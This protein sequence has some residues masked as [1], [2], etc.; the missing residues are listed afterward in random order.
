MVFIIL[1]LLLWLAVSADQCVYPQDSCDNASY[2]Q[3]YPLCTLLQQGGGHAFAC[4]GEPSL[5]GLSKPASWHLHMLFPNKNCENCSAHFQRERPGF[6]FAGA[7]LF[8]ERVANFLNQLVVK[9]KGSPPRLAINGTRARL[10]LNYNVCGEIFDIKAGAPANFVDEPCIY[11]V[12]S[13]M[14]HGGPWRNPSLHEGYPN[15]SFFLPG[16][17]WLP[18]AVPMLRAWLDSERSA[19]GGYGQYTFAI[20]PNTGCES[21]DHFK[22]IE[23]LGP[24]LPLSDDFSCNALGCNQMCQANVKSA[25]PANC[26]EQ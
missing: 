2:V 5:C 21:H 18:G 19:V 7:M 16:D 24:P 14:E 20:H 3:R 4:I 23:W 25:Y 8:R 1:C 6:S 9:V 11:E 17:F 26:G 12:D 22:E 15:W 10:D 13:V